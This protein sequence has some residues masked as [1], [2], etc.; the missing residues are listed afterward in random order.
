MRPSM[1]TWSAAAPRGADE[2]GGAPLLQV[3][4]LRNSLSFSSRRRLQPRM[5]SLIFCM[6][7]G[8]ARG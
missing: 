8:M 2:G 1:S 6:S 4:C 5:A 3:F 7:V